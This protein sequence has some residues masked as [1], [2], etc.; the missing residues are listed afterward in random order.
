MTTEYD[1]KESALEDGIFYI[2]YKNMD[3][4]KKILEGLK[5]ETKELGWP[6]SKTVELY[7]LKRPDG[8][9]V[10]IG[11]GKFRNGYDLWLVDLETG[12]SMR[13]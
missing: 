9:E 13:M 12:V 2:G 6:H 7:K 10:G 4:P 8:M 3:S 5:S 1:S 11:V